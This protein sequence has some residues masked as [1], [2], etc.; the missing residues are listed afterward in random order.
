MLMFTLTSIALIPSTGTLKVE[1]RNVMA[2]TRIETIKSM[3]SHDGY[4]VVPVGV[5]FASL[6]FDWDD[7]L[8][9]VVMWRSGHMFQ[10]SH[11]VG[12]YF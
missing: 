3:V 9:P 6:I 4:A 1:N 5:C 2:D 7:M 12:R 11:G 10:L 8:P